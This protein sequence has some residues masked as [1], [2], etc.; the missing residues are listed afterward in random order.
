MRSLAVAVL[1]LAACHGSTDAAEPVP[2]PAA[3]FP[4]FDGSVLSMVHMNHSWYVGGA[5]SHVTPYQT[6]GL[7]HLDMSGRVGSCLGAFDG[8][9]YA[10]VRSGP[11][12]FVGGS[13][14]KFHDVPTAGL[15]KLDAATCEIDATFSASG[16]FDDWV[17]AL[18]VSGDSLYVGGGFTT[19]RGASANHIAKLDTTTGALDQV[20]S[21]SATNGFTAS[22][23]STAVLTLAV[24]GSSVFA[25][26]QF[27]DY[28]GV[29]DSAWAIAKLDATTG[30]LDTTFSPAGRDNNGFDCKLWDTYGAVCSQ[31][32]PA[33]YV[34][35][36]DGTSVFVGGSFS[37]YRGV[38]NAANNLAKLDVVTGALDTTFSPPGPTANGFD[39]AV[40]AL[41][42]G[43]GS[44]YAGG[45]MHNQ[46]DQEANYR[47]AYAGALVALDPASGTMTKV[48]NVGFG[49][50]V[51]ALAASVDALF[52]A[53]GAS[54]TKIDLA[55]GQP[56]EFHP[57]LGA[58]VFDNTVQTLLVDGSRLWAAGGF[59]VYGGYHI[60]DLVKL[61]ERSFEPDV[62]FSPPGDNWTVAPPDID[63]WIDELAAA[64]SSLFVNGYFVTYRGAPANRAATLDPETGEL[65]ESV[66]RATMLVFEDSLYFTTSQ[67][68]YNSRTDTWTDYFVN[69]LDLSSGAVTTFPTAF[70]DAAPRALVASGDA[71]YTCGPVVAKMD[72]FTGAIDPAFSAG[73]ATGPCVATSDALYVGSYSANT[74]W[75]TK[76]DLATGAVD[77]SFALPLLATSA[78]YSESRPVL[79]AADDAL[80]VLV[81]SET[82]ETLHKVDRYTGAL[83]TGFN[84]TIASPG[85]LT[86]I[87][88]LGSWLYVG[89]TFRTSDASNAGM[90]D[91][92]TGAW[93]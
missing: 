53:Y 3:E 18:A 9:V 66:P 71:I 56:T 84:L 32:P 59:S 86:T 13:F 15:A 21:P 80:Y 58:A 83:D 24:A 8:T 55:S 44:L 77:S 85:N 37:D 51:T 39:R 79:L 78:T 73:A 46:L 68:H 20:F 75:A 64:P 34:I 10:V 61:D 93:R 26:G 91:A 81:A 50:Y 11:S 42:L 23:G 90:V 65:L 87:Q 33:V 36:T 69:R 30:A 54:I 40:N 41:V 70:R 62:I 82:E 60:P 52:V 4:A 22:S 38:G 89:G 48:F 67:F 92:S 19:Y 47:G 17:Y 76:L 25:G 63:S 28:R 27:T 43:N 74:P 31:Y 29:A 88:H 14:T 12:I 5:F 35:V 6:R 7:A 2:D 57:D 16:G 1:A 72:R 49:Y 45:S